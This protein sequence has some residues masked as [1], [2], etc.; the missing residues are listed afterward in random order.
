M[1]RV[2]DGSGWNMVV[3]GTGIERSQT[4]QRGAFGKLGNLWLDEVIPNFESVL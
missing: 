3:A 1:V 2:S 4:F